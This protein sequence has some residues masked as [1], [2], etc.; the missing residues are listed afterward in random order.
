MDLHTAL[1]VVQNGIPSQSSL[2]KNQLLEFSHRHGGGESTNIPKLQSKF[3]EIRIKGEVVREN[4]TLGIKVIFQK[5]KTLV[6]YTLQ[7]NP[8]STLTFYL[9]PCMKS[10]FHG[11]RTIG[12]FGNS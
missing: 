6:P 8:Y 3:R 2:R 5:N 11:N 7:D 12:L 1:N 9:P 4:M 10:L